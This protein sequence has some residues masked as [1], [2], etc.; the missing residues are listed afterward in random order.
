RSVLDGRDEGIAGSN[1]DEG[2]V[3]SLVTR[4]AEESQANRVRAGADV[5]DP[6]LLSLEV[7]GGLDGVRLLGGHHFGLAR[8]DAELADGLDLLPQG[9]ELDGV[10]VSAR[11]GVDVAGDDLELGSLPGALVDQG[12][13]DLFSIEVTELLGEHVRQIDILV[14]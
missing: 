13:V 10:A 14:E 3:G 6:Q 2:R 5:G 4:L 9:V 12:D 1:G 11:T 8:R 7:R